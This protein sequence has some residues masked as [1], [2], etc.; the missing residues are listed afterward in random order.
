[1]L[2]I[3]IIG[4]GRIADQHATEILKIKEAEMV[5]AADSELL[6]AKQFA[7]RFKVNG[8]FNNIEDLLNNAN[9]DVIHITTPPQ[10]H[11]TLA[12]EC[13]EAGCHIF[14]EKPFTLNTGEARELI[15]LA[16]KYNLKVTVGH[17]AQ[18]SHAAMRMR[19]MIK[20]GYLGGDP[21]HM[22]SVWCYPFTDP[23][24]AKAI[25]GDNNHWIRTL[26]GRYLHDII[27]HGIS[28][29]AEFIKSDTPKVLA[30]GYV[31][32]LLKSLK[33][34]DIID[35]LRVIIIDDDARSAYFTFSSQMGPPIKQFRIYGP[36]NSLIIDHEHQSVSKV[37]KNYK[38]YLNHF[39]PG[40]VDSKENISNSLRNIFKFIKSDFY[41]ESGR[42]NLIEIFYQSVLDKSP[43]PIPYREILLTS[44]IMDNIFGQI[45][46]K[47]LGCGI[48]LSPRLLKKV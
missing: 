9:P 34:D 47:S 35:E 26:P 42:K 38:Y 22:E 16:I 21:V 3:G 13:L 4:C 10:S 19:E 8:Y 33:E 7:E 24:Y 29:I 5:G 27:S 39:V 43:L 23:G 31:G 1:M 44:Y 30:Y 40:F 11:F 2:K 14:L 6:M 25:L 36:Q 45:Y 20:S 12:K 15:D 41:F 48:P 32:A 18:F 28:R 37:S 46:P 17:N